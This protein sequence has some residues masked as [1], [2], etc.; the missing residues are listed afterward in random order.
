MNQ[1][2]AFQSIKLTLENCEEIEFLGEY[3]EL[4]IIDIDQ[5]NT[6][7]VASQKKKATTFFIKINALANS[8]SS[9]CDSISEAVCL[10]FDRIQQYADIVYIEII[11]KNGKSECVETTWQGDGINNPYQSSVLDS[12]NNLCIS[13]GH[14]R[15]FV[16]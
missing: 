2:E 14:Q 16:R 4:L 8:T 6:Q 1:I 11:Y 9:C 13:I 7:I 15:V 3:I 10:P 12:E 5:A